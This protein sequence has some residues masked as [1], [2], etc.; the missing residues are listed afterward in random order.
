ME[1]IG[2][3]GE[4]DVLLDVRLSSSSSLGLT[5]R[6]SNRM[7]N[8]S[9]SSRTATAAKEAC[10]AHRLAH[11]TRAA[12]GRKPDQQPEDRQL[13]HIRVACPHHD[14]IVAI[15]QEIAVQPIRPRFHG[16]EDAE[17]SGAMG[18]RRLGYPPAVASEFDVA[19]Q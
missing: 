13:V 15:Q 19:T 8:T 17:Q 5:N 1:V 4:R 7:G 9:A 16:E 10:S 12:N 11:D 2:L 6:R 14:A 18:D 3:S